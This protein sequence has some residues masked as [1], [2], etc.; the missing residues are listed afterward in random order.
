MN[1][2]I[3]YGNNGFH[4]EQDENNSRYEITKEY[5]IYLLSEQ[6]KGM[7][8]KA[9]SKGKPIATNQE[10]SKKNEIIFKINNIKNNLNLTDYKIIKCYEA[11]MRQQPLP[12]N[13]EELSAQRE[14][15]R[16]EINQ[17]EQELAE[18]E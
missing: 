14:A 15:W 9:D 1:D 5:W 18:L 4:L 12:Y 6:E 8:I 17:L 11:F 16:A 7:L 13:L 3:Y 10:F 2:K